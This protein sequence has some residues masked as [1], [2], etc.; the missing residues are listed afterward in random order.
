MA[1]CSECEQFDLQSFRS[2]KYMQRGYAYEDVKNRSTPCD[3]CDLLRN[4]FGHPPLESENCWI[5][6][7]LLGSDQ[8][9][10]RTGNGHG[11]GVAFIRAF[12]GVRYTIQFGPSTPFGWSE[13]PRGQEV[14]LSACADK[15]MPYHIV[16][17]RVD[18]EKFR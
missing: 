3:F 11:L 4:C 16:L 13:Y 10:V 12:L 17:Y 7:E 1:L 8:K 2:D 14:L 9:R 18:L 15:G 6:F 5:H